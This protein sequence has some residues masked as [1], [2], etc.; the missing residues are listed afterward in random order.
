MECSMCGC[1]CDNC[2]CSRGCCITCGC[3]NG[4]IE[5]FS[6]KRLADKGELTL[7]SLPMSGSVDFNS[8]VLSELADG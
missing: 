6:S 1:D 7:D 3:C 4:T 5:Q 2:G 8:D